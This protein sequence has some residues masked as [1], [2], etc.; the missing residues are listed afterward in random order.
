MP[1]TG[2]VPSQVSISP[3]GKCASYLRPRDD[4]REYME[5]WL[6]ELASGE[7]RQLLAGVP[8]QA[9]AAIGEAE[10]EEEKAERERRRRFAYGITA[11][12]W[13]PERDEILIPAKGAAFL[14][15]VA[16]G[17]ARRVTP[18]HTRQ[19]GIQYSA[20]GNFVS[21][22]RNGDLY[23]THIASGDETRITQDGGGTVANG[24]PEFIAQE[25]MKRFDGHWW[26]P[27]ES[28]IAFA[29]VDTASIAQTNRYEASADG[30]QVVAQ[31]YP[32][33]GAA[34]AEVRLGIANLQSGEVLW[35]D[36]SLAA[37]DYLARV[38][39]APDGSLYVQAQSRDQ[40]RLAL[41]QF[42]DGRW[43]EIITE[44]AAK[45]INLGDRLKFLADGR[46]LW[47]SEQSGTPQ[48]TI[49][50]RN[51]H[52]EPLN[53]GLGR[54]NRILG[55]TN[56]HA[57]ATGHR[58]DPTLQ[59][60]YRIALD[61]GDCQQLTGSSATWHEG[62]VNADK[63]VVVAI[64]SGSETPS[65]L[66]VLDEFNC[67]DVL[68]VAI[69]AH[70]PYFPFLKAH[71]EPEI[72]DLQ[73]R[74]NKPNG[75]RLHYRIA[76]PTRWDANRRYPVVVHVYGGPGVQ[77][78]RQDFAPLM[79][80]LFAQAG[81][82]VFEL[83]NRG[84]ANRNLDFEQAIYGR[85]GHVEV[86]DQFEGVKM[87]R[88]LPWVDPERIGIF[89]HSYGGY[90]VL[91]CLANGIDFASGVAVAPVTDWRLYD[92][93][94]TERYL[95]TPQQNPEGYAKSAALSDAASIQA[96]LLLM[97]GMADDN[98]LFAH[99]LKLIKNLQ[100]A[101]TPFELMTYPNAKHALQERSVAIHRY[102]AVLDFFRRTLQ[103]K[104]PPRQGGRMV[105]AKPPSR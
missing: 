19:N 27:D 101:G 77:R 52:S 80:Q 73:P 100:D 13:H 18:S 65:A 76:K 71:S 12:A 25:E 66:Q 103:S 102:N 43:R 93:H 84:S 69:D 3:D 95:G 48:I 62:A 86:E 9:L 54:I 46:L 11:Y 28:A 61:T 55:A 42:E 24:L 105:T 53:A 6:V 90:M 74:S 1:L 89:G 49:H 7:V 20:N 5:L 96:P 50:H 30:T 98:V 45:W 92:T 35:L 15:Q 67:R 26:S 21:Y 79:L 85:L 104:E 4:N 78:A 56:E 29:R 70:H 36:W 2:P 22:V 16:D 17:T 63:G 41:R 38:Q 10:S 8:E 37:D 97:H 99:S 59:H 87:L 44:T 82:G 83:D 57:W 94:Y 88:E 14:L 40:K 75:P 64:R 91:K 68:K 72:H 32:M 39:F 58:N 23:F 60:L 51:G 47:I 81:F 34:N 33:A 31:R